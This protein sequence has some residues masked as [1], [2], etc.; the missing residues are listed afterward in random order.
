T[1][2]SA[3]KANLWVASCSSVPIG[4]ISSISISYHISLKHR[5]EDRHLPRK[6]LQAQ[7]DGGGGGGVAG[8]GGGGEATH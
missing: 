3:I 1:S 4:N 2:P 8:G 6:S 5:E 7:L